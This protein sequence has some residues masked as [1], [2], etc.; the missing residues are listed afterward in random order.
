MRAVL[1]DSRFAAQRR[2]DTYDFRGKLWW[3]IGATTTG[4]QIWE[5][6]QANFDAA[7][8]LLIQRIRGTFLDHT[9]GGRFLSVAEAPEPGHITVHFDDPEHAAT[10]TPAVLT[11][12]IT[13]SADDRD[14]TA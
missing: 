3:P 14:F 5:T 4:T 11:A 7:I 8:D 10:Q 2:I 12:T 6:E 13:Y 1:H 9:H